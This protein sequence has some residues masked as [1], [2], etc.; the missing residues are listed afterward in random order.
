MNII[1]PTLIFTFSL[2][3]TAS[4]AAEKGLPGDVSHGDRGQEE[5]AAQTC[6]VGCNPTSTSTERS[7]DTTKNR[8]SLASRALP[9][10]EAKPD[11]KESKSA[12]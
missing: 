11:S 8:A 2:A 4:F 6:S 3:T 9:T 10:D 12:E 7:V 5:T 1:I